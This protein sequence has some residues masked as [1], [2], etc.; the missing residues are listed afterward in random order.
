MPVEFLTKEQKQQYG[1]YTEA[2]NE[3][4]LARYFHLDEFDLTLVKK[5]R[6]KHNQLG[7]ALQLT[8]VRF[9]GTFVMDFDNVPESVVQ[10]VAR[11]LGIR[12]LE[13]LSR[14]AQRK[15]TQ[16]DHHRE[17][18]Q[19][20]G[21][22]E[23]ADGSLGFRLIRCLYS[24]A[25][26]ANERPSVLF[27]HG[28]A[29]L[30]ENKVLLPG[31][32]VLIR[33]VAEVRERA[34]NRLWTKLA[35]M[36]DC[37]D[38]NELYALLEPEQENSRQ[39]RL[40]RLRKG[41]TTVS[42]PAFISA[43]KRYEEMLDFPVPETAFESLPGAR[44]QAVARHALTSTVTKIRRMPDD[45]RVSMLLAFVHTHRLTTLDDAIDI[46]DML[47]T[48][49][50][51]S[52]KTIGQKKR[53]RSLK[54]LDKS[55]LLL[56]K[57]CALLLDE[58]IDDALVRETIYHRFPK[59]LLTQSLTTIKEL[60]RPANAPYHQELVEQYGRVRL[61]L[62]TL[63]AKLPLK[64]TPSGEPL[65]EAFHY[66][67]DEGVAH[68]RFLTNAPLEIVKPSWKYLVLLEAGQVSKQ[69][70]CLCFLSQL[71][72]ALRRR[73][74]FLEDSHNWS[75][76][77]AKL[78][79]EEA[80]RHTRPHICR[81]LN[82]P[83]D[84]QNALERLKYQLDSTFKEVG[85]RFEGNH[86]V[87]IELKDNKARLNISALEPDQEPLSTTTL[88]QAITEL[89]PRVDLTELLVEINAITGF[90]SEFTHVSESKARAHDLEISLCAVLMSEACNIG[91]EPLIKPHI[92]ALTRSRLQWVKQNYLRSETITKA[93]ARLVD[94]QSTLSIANI[95]GG[96]E[97]ASADGMRFVTP[98]R[99]INGG[100][101]RKYFGSHKGITWYN[102]MS[103]QYSGFHDITVT[104][105]LRD[106]LFVLEGLLEQETSLNPTEIMTDTAGSSDLIFG[107][108]ALLGYQFSPRLAD[109]GSSSLWRFDK[110]A[111]YGALN[112][113]SKST[114]RSDRILVQWD[115]MLR[116]AGSLKL[117][118]VRASELIRTLLK[119]ER[120]SG[121]TQ[122]IIE[123]GRA[124][125]TLYLLKYLDDEEYRRRILTQLNRGESRHAVARAI[126]H[127]KRG[128]IRK[129]YREG[130]EDQLSALGLVT[131][132]V[133]LWNSIYM[134]EAVRHL[135]TT[136][137]V[138]D[139]DIA[140]ISPLQTRHIN[141]LGQYSFNVADNI[142]KGELR[143]LYEDTEEEQGDL[144]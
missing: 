128:E 72:D 55:A 97:V 51:A 54:D 114:L 26:I 75:D 102:F 65:L 31:V 107:L 74:L 112:E 123:L 125:K 20:Y 79:S 121:L 7:F 126:C 122:G 137:S 131:N 27:D 81:S 12:H 60:T 106:S 76:P 56:S 116:V 111:D 43:V 82:Y 85:Q 136:H 127:G 59:S 48:Q 17:I 73:D 24:R 95:W 35:S 124:N 133:I 77:R 62:P 3:L 36:L 117:G 139:E 39:S 69:G 15:N 68:K 144:S 78:L 10:C 57:V 84:P 28:T 130:Q 25:W 143:P 110:N 89:L 34:A 32:T 99:T 23:L 135:S 100:P 120:P 90:T 2:P 70:Y 4:Q 93:N 47:I 45:K 61:F 5:R 53:L 83:S 1:R 71:Q 129:K 37:T 22:R 142:L 115:E 42:G 67:R 94:H 11:Q 9:L 19:I 98:V 58:E 80:W 134:Q 86:Q 88:R 18:K 29:W 119:S 21:Y 6:G 103:N 141:M 63:L 8:S 108:F 104:G 16:W 109:A 44:V 64:A 40:E 38:K 50:T 33:L 96:G 14:Y 66:L 46:L 30:I 92:P 132:A 105:T 101:N 52:A 138:D 87:S 118:K 49:M 140:R 91:L 13:V 41:P 113:V